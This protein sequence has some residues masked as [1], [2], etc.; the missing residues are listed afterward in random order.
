MKIEDRLPIG[1]TFPQQSHLCLQNHFSAAACC[2]DF[3]TYHAAEATRLRFRS[4]FSIDQLWMPV[5]CIWQQWQALT[6]V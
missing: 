5:E 2:G 4:A 1:S 6:F 3:K